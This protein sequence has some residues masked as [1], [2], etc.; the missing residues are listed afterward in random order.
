MF[1]VL[2]T[3]ID[4][5]HLAYREGE[6]TCRE[7]VET[8]IDRIEAYDENGPELNAIVTINPHATARA[9]ELDE[10]LEANGFTG[11]LHGI[12][13]VIKDQVETADVTTTFGSEA[14]ADYQPTADATLVTR[15]KAAGAVVLAKTNLPDWATSWFGY[16]SVSGRT[17]NPYDPA[18][19]PGGSSSGT[20]AA[21]AAN[22]GTV[23]IGEDTGGSIRLPAAYNNLFGIRVTPGLLSRTGMSP[24]VVSQDTPGP[25]ARTTKELAQILDVTVGYDAADE[26]T[27]V[28]ELADDAGYYVDRLDAEALDGARIGVLRDAFGDADDPESGPVTRL[29]DDAIE[30]MADAGAELVDPVE[31]PEL[32]THLE[33]TLLYILQSKHDLNEFFAARD[34]APVDSVEELYESGQYHE[35]LDLFIG[36]AEEGPE[37]PTDNPDY[38][39]SVAAQQVFQRAVLNVYAEHDLDVLLC[40]DVQVIPPLAEA[41]EAGELDTL[42]FPTNTI[43]ASQA[44]LCAVSAPAGLTSDGHP[45]GVELIGK[46]YDEATLLSLAHAYEQ[47]ADPR[48]P[49]ETTPRL[50]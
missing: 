39:E 29:V 16:S 6:L 46:P 37:D 43:I 19:D 21:V 33:R 47:V 3:T 4:E 25:M 15:L 38:W 11:P 41:I 9:D 36:I 20:G 7:L 2:E 24:L 32:D 45:V 1:D 23:G 30:T 5:I 8:Y 13:I 40:P 49:P 34:D 31:I 44:G 22:L 48:V 27:A 42:T 14:F 12:P 28:N 18:R 50:E 10:A 26:Y 35:I 17:K